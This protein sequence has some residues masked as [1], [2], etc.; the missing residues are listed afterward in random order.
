MGINAEY[1][2]ALREKYSRDFFQILTPF[3][4][5]RHLDATR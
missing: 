4:E 3:R 2:G 5:N 1:M